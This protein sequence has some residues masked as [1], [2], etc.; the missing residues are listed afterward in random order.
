MIRA[1]TR[2][3]IPRI[4]EMGRAFYAAS[5][6]EAIAP[7]SIPSIAGLAILTMEQGVM[8]VAEV[9]GAVVGMACLFIEPFTFNPSVMVAN[10]LAWWIDPEHRG[11]L[12]AAKMLDAIECAC[13]EREVDVIRMATLEN[14]PPQAATLYERKGYRRSD[15]HYTRML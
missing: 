4:V 11:T 1:A 5:G 13:R 14:S 7:A 2:D 3:D 10:E 15:S 6:Y 12:L 9:N 8:L